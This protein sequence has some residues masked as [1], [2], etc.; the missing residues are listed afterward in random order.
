VPA[1]VASISQTRARHILLAAGGGLSAAQAQEQLQEVRKTI[2]SGQTTFEAAARAR[3]QDGSA[4][5]GG[6]LGW[7]NP[8]MFVPE[9]EQAMDSLREGEISAPLVSR[10]GVHLIQV[11]E[12]R[13]VEPTQEQQREQVRKQLRAQKMDERFVSWLSELRARAFVEIREP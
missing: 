4:A 8:G 11:L 9:F 10:F 7:A 6:D 3:S 2:V 1:A 13:R 5:Q 12:R